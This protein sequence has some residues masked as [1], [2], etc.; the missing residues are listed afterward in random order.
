MENTKLDG[1]TVQQEGGLTTIRQNKFWIARLG[2]SLFM[3]FWLTGWSFG[4]GMMIKE[5]LTKF[6]WFTLLFS[7]PFFVAWIAGAVILLSTLFGTRQISLA[8]DRL[9]FVHRVILPISK[10]EVLFEEIVGLNV[11]TQGNFSNLIVQSSGEH[12]TISQNVSAERN[13][14]LR[15]FLYQQ[16]PTIE[17]P[18]ISSRPEKIM[19]AGKRL[20]SPA[21]CSWYFAESFGR[22][23]KLAN[24]GSWELRSILFLMGINLFWNGIVSVFL[25]KAITV[26]SEWFELLFLS[27]F[28]LIGLVMA[29]VLLFAVIDPFRK[30]TY[31][32]SDY[33]IEWSWKYFG[34]GRTKTW[35][36]NAP[37]EIGIWLERDDIPDQYKDGTD[38]K[39][40]FSCRGTKQ[41]EIDSLNLAEAEWIGTQLDSEQTKYTLQETI[42]ET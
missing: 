31:A 10:T 22:E 38:Y 42:K 14:A 24:Q 4:C 25:V 26:G 15:D 32:F 17:K 27:P 18:R 19:V 12:L 20:E 39:L 30:I 8:K 11:I 7:I 1:F 21:N 6:A 2:I 13:E 5:L 35:E 36:I 3:A 28:V 34:I 29:V 33:E 9:E 41:M 23:T 16:I 37:V 40:V